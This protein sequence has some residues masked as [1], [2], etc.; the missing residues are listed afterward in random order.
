MSE[1]KAKHKL[2]LVDGH[3]LAFRSFYAFTKGGEGGL[4]TKDGKPTSVTF[5]FLK[6]L[7]ENCKKI[8]PEAVTI[9]FDTAEPTF[10]HKADS[11]Y[12]ANRDVAPDIFFEDLDQL[13]IILRDD[14]KIPLCIAPGF[15]ADDVLGTLAN[16]AVKKSWEVFILSGD[17]DLFQLVDDQKGISVLYMGGGR[18]SSSSDPFHIKEADVIEKLGVKPSKVVELKALTGDSSDNIPGVKGVGPKTAISLLNESNDLD[19]IYHLLDQLTKEQSKTLKS[20]V[21]KGALIS[22]LI[23]DRK[24]AYLSKYLAEILTEVPLDNDEIIPLKTIDEHSLKESL[25]DLELNSLA[26]Q[27][28]VFV[29]ALSK[30]GYSINKNLI[31]D[32]AINDDTNIK[33]CDRTSIPNI[34]P[35]II[36]S[37]DQL[38]KLIKILNEFNSTDD[39]I[40]IDTETTHLNPF[41]AELVGI[42]FCWG[43]QPDQMAYIPIMHSINNTI[44]DPQCSNQLAL[45]VVLKSLSYWI[46][47]EDHPKVLQNC[48]YDRLVF[49]R[50]GIE[51]K[52]VVLDTLLADYL[53]D[54]SAKHSLDA[55]SKRY[56]SYTPI[57]FNDIVP[58]G[59]NFADVSIN[60][61]S[62]YCGM[63]VY[64]TKRISTL[65]I[66]QIRDRG[67]KLL[68]LYFDIE[69]PLENV[70]AV[71]ESTGIR[72]DIPYLKELSLELVE[73][74]KCLEQNVSDYAGAGFNLSSP[75]QLAELLFEKL[76]LDRKK[77]RK[78]KTGWSTD[79]RVLEKLQEDHPIVPQIVEYRVIHKLLTT[80]VD[81]LPE[82][83]EPE[84]GRVHTDFNQA[85]T[86]TGRLSSSNPNLQNIPVRTEFSKRIR[87]AFL[88]KEGWSLI[89]ADYSQIELRILAHLSGEEVL[90]EA[91]CNGQD[92]HSVT[93]SILLEKDQVNDD[94]RRLGKT[95]NFGVI[96]GMGSKL[97][98]RST[99]LTNQEAKIFLEKFHQKYKKVFSYLELQERLAL[100]RGYVETIMGRRRNF[101]FDKNGLGRLKGKEPYEIDLDNARRAGMEAQQ[102]RAAANAPIQG[103]SADIIKIAMVNLHKKLSES[104]YPAQ[105]L[106]Q[107]HDELVLEVEPSA[108]EEVKD[109]LLKTMENAVNL[110]VPLVVECGVG[111]NWMDAK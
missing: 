24:N 45:D 91:Y 74:L 8:S 14:L 90:K 41:K 10:R 95:I 54:S 34:S 109:L 15:E 66:D 22:K 67:D 56:F 80:Y 37:M 105:M 44:L 2:L 110:S 69:G 92:V 65:L 78:T 9:A 47:S 84:T 12:K 3:S 73:R 6:S 96:Y 70:L 46:T 29:N 43:D 82:L 101:I 51:L 68:S 94:E 107:V 99:G 32:T 64:L 72:I 75:K 87:K 40:A 62:K 35:K 7:L 86:A 52:G 27:I 20:N 81:A 97:L 77:S 49:L 11:N 83:V 102:L 53:L 85:V 19:G 63:D 13:K 23:K 48:K 50:H 17:R 57:S 111:S 108:V 33:S 18:Y 103:S 98:A 26:S 28:P 16:K 71:M 89:T 100:T 55:M 79:A 30:G 38:E 93:A 25:E 61:A 42:G 39:P 106:L 88:P 5:G 59:G 36:T 21:I 58:K 60:E 31:D 76:G 4:S 1:D 104:S